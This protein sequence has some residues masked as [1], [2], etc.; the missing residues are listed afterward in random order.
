MTLSEHLSI[1]PPLAY[2][3]IA[4]TE[5]YNL[6]FF[7]SQRWFIYSLLELGSKPGSY[8]ALGLS[9]LL[10]SNDSLV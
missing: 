1:Y 5:L 7:L 8:I 3:E 2:K 4:T 10:F 6:I 9:A